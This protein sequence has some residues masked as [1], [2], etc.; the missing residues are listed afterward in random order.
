MQY[1]LVAENGF[2]KINDSLNRLLYRKR[3]IY[4]CTKKFSYKS[5]KCWDRSGDF[6]AGNRPLTAVRKAW[7]GFKVLFEPDR[8]KAQ[9]RR[10]LWRQTTRGLWDYDIFMERLRFIDEDDYDDVMMR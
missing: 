7:C 10:L 9:E 8:G 5:A 3:S 6:G 4:G 2:L 1:A